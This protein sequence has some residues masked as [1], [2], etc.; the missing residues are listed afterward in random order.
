L[1]LN[2]LKNFPKLSVGWS[3]AC[4]AVDSGHSIGCG[5]GELP[6]G[7]CQSTP[8]VLAVVPAVLAVV[9][10][11]VLVVAVVVFLVVLLVVL[12][13]VVAVVVG[14]GVPG[15]GVDPGKWSSYLPG[16]YTG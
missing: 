14:K 1:Y 12:F 16:P 15:A 2:N 9:L 13:V 8:A 10:V 3:S 7:S 4:R 6:W 5:W 11:V